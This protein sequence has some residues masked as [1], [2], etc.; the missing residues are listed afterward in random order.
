MRVGPSSAKPLPA[1]VSEAAAWFVE[2]RAQDMSPEARERF[3]AWLRRSPEH[4]QAYLEV[5]GAWAAL[6]TSDSD[7]RIDIEALLARARAE[8]DVVPHPATTRS[9]TSPKSSTPARVWQRPSSRVS[10][11]LAACVLLVFAAVWLATQ[12]KTYATG[13]GEQQTIR[14]ADGSVVE[15][16]SLSRL[17][18]RIGAH[19]R[20]AEL[21]SGQ[22]MF[23][24][25]KDPTRPFIVDTGCTKVRA[26]GTEFD[27]YKKRGGIVVTVVEGRVAVYSG[28]FEDAGTRLLGDVALS[29]GH[30]VTV[31]Q[32]TP[33]R[34]KPVDAEA[35]TAWV[36]KRLVFEETALS[37]VVDEF[38]RYNTV[39]LVIED[40]VLQRVKISGVYSST[41]PASLLGFLRAEPA[42][43]VVETPQKILIRRK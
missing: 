41:D 3:M 34:P 29:A 12:G 7:H 35:A 40:P 26:V 31:V 28:R 18:V 8:A 42:I 25:A 4:I 5:A 21:V 15:L 43:D 2:F 33:S 11:L 37:E 16:N 10:A 20:L 22:A 38:N 9:P 36:Q 6:P 24:V 32:N 19:E 27:V 13:I 1:I 23:H 17:T 30:Q 39:P 14:L